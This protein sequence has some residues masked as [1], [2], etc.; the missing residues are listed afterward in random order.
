MS[1]LDY[2]N[3]ILIG[4][5]KTSISLL[6]RVQN[7]AVQN[8]YWEK[9][10]YKSSSKYLEELHWLPIQHRI[11]FKAV[12]Q[13]FQCIHRL[14]PNY[15]KELII[16]KK[17]RRQGLRSEDLIKQHEIPR[18]SRHTFTAR[19]FRVKGPSLWNQL[20]ECIKK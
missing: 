4:L 11:N 8:Y 9:N 18:I 15:L 2:A 7:M 1:H 19:S 10:K 17:W 6:Q 5:P 13:V 20:P 3:S 14:A 12:T 16:P